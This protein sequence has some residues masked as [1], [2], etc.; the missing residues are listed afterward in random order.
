MRTWRRLLSLRMQRSQNIAIRAN[1]LF[2]SKS[3][4]S[5]RQHSSIWPSSTSMKG[6]GNESILWRQMADLAAHLV[7]PSPAPAAIDAVRQCSKVNDD[8]ACCNEVWGA[9]CQHLR[10]TLGM[11]QM[12]DIESLGVRV[13]PIVVGMMK[14]KFATSRFFQSWLCYSRSARNASSNG[15]CPALSFF[16]LWEFWRPCSCRRLVRLCEVDLEVFSRS[17]WSSLGVLREDAQRL[18]NE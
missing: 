11:L 13:A 17:H 7:G 16:G 18:R 10:T 6:K 14:R 9:R 3:S 12:H 4:S 1:S 8:A 15:L 2:C 5:P